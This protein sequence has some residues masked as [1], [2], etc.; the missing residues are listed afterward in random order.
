MSIATGTIYGLYNKSND[1]LVY[2]GQNITTLD[3]RLT[4]HKSDHSK[5]RA[6]DNDNSTYAKMNILV[7]DVHDLIIKP[8]EVFHNI[9]KAEL[10]SKE[11]QYIKQY[12]PICNSTH[13]KYRLNAKLYG[14]THKITNQ[15]LYID[16]YYNSDLQKTFADL[17]KYIQY[18]HKSCKN[19]QMLHHFGF[20]NFKIQHITDIKEIKESEINTIL[21]NYVNELKPAISNQE[22]WDKYEIHYHNKHIDIIYKFTLDHFNDYGTYFNI[23]DKVYAYLDYYPRNSTLPTNRNCRFVEYNYFD[24]LLDTQCLKT[25]LDSRKYP[26]TAF[27]YIDG[28]YDFISKFQDFYSFITPD[29][30]MQYHDIYHSYAFKI[31]KDDYT[32]YQSS[33]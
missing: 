29:I 11:N 19:Y 3:K 1:K 4:A 22:K 26:G 8:I 28:I 17:D 6:R 23:F 10:S 21:T 5:Y 30:F 15:L 27:K 16:I 13:T 18:F 9:T 31:Y 2:I 32:L 7:P 12:K 24:G 14:I 33:F 20:D 25:F